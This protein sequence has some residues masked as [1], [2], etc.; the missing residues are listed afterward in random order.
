M[1]TFLFLFVVCIF[2]AVGAVGQVAGGYTI[3]AQ[4]QVFAM[5]DHP[6]RASETAMGQEHNLL[7][8][9][10]STYAQGERPA[11]E[12]MQS[13]PVTPL[14]DTARALKAEHAT[15]KKAQIVW[16]N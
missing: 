11:W 15:A 16:S 5:P 4:P 9:V 10:Q 13:A 7:G 3:S 2:C 14:G 6:M 8:S 12:V 1:K